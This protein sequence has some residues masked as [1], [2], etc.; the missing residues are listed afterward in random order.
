[1]RTDHLI[2]VKPIIYIPAMIFILGTAVLSTIYQSNRLENLHAEYPDIS[3]EGSVNGVISDIYTRKGASFV[4]LKGGEKLF[5]RLSC[6]YQTKNKYFDES[7]Q[8]G[9]SLVK[10]IG[11]DTLHV[12]NEEGVEYF[13][14][15]KYINKQSR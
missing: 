8:L 2:K 13:V 10:R 5:I 15:G 6:N 9:D 11:S 1:M 12:I 7:I 3:N 4:T 14:I